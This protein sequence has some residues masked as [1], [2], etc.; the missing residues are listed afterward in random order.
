MCGD[1]GRRRQEAALEAVEGPF[2]NVPD[3]EVIAQNGIERAPVLASEA[4]GAH[5]PDAEEAKPEREE[6]DERPSAAHRDE[7]EEER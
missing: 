7:G 6:A 2:V 3:A 5:C 1:K 4:P